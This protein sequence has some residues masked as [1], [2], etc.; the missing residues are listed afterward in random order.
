MNNTLPAAAGIGLRSPH[1][2]EVL[3]RQFSAV[4]WFEIH[5]ENYFADGGPVLATLDRIRADY[6]LAMHGVGLSLGSADPLDLGHLTKLKR[7]ADRVQPA[8]V[9][10]HL[11]WSGIDGRHF[12]DLLPLPYTD[13]ALAHVC[14]GARERDPGLS[15]PRTRRRE[16]VVLLRVSGVTLPERE[17]VAAVAARTGCGLLIDV[18]NIYVNA[19]NHG[20]DPRAY[21]DGDSAGRGRRSPSRRIRRQRTHRDRHPR[22]AGR[23]RGVAALRRGDRALRAGTDADRMGHRHSRFAVLR[24]EAARRKPSSRRTMPS[25]P[26]LQRRFADAL[27]G[28]AANDPAPGLAIYRNAVFANYRNALAATYRVVRELTGAPF[29]GA[30]VDAFALAHPSTGRRPQRLRQRIRGVPHDISVC[31]RPAL[32]ARCRAARMGDG[33]GAARSRRD[34]IRGGDAR[35]TG[36]HSRRRRRAATLQ[37]RSLVPAPAVAV[38][39]DAHLAGAPGGI[40][41]QAA[42]RVRRSAGPPH[43]PPRDG[44]VVVE[45]LPP[46]DFAWL[47][48]LQGGAD[49]TRALEAAQTADATFDLG[50]A[51]RAYLVDGTLTG[52]AGH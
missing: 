46:G 48:A 16:R 21:S 25:L 38:S 44:A 52:I 4:A 31:A 3:D 34:R 17:F 23:T 33:R 40:R 45:R 11:C 35:R 1:V 47:D 49:L 27:H 24:R 5:S 26:E 32:S 42:R 10:E 41:R 13:E 2:R 51:L 39:G 14:A 28:D 30:A 36:C 8:V 18:N 22:R 29:F 43:G 50:T 7:L 9:S 37:P 12:N 19:R 20:I 6:P 15:R